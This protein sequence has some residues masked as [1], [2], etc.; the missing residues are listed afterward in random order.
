MG[1]GRVIPGGPEWP[2]SLIFSVLAVILVVARFYRFRPFLDEPHAFRQA[3][4]SYSAQ[5]FYRFGMNIFRP[6]IISMGD[7]RH[8]LIEF[9]VPE[10]ITAIVYHVTGPTLL[11][12]RLV[13][14]GF[15]LGSAY[16]LFRVIAL[17]QDRLL[18]WVA[19]LIYMAA[20][21][22]IYFSRAIHIDSAALCFGHA[23]LFYFLRYGE[24]G[25]RRDLVCAFITSA[26]GFLVK[27]PY[28]FYLILPA[29]YIQLA[30]GQ[31]RHA[32]IS[33]LAF[34]AALTVGLAWFSYAQSVNRRAPDLSFVRGY[35]ITND[36]VDFYIGGAGQRLSGE[37]WRTIGTRLRREIAADFWWPLVPLA[38][39]W[40]RRLR[41]AWSFAA[42]WT[43]GSFVFLFAFF[44]VNSLHNYYQLNF[45]APFALWM[46]IPLYGALVEEGRFARLAQSL[47]LVVLAAYV[48]AG[49]RMAIRN[50]Y[51]VDTVGIDVGEFVHARTS[52]RDLVIMAFNDA[53]YLDPRYL[54]YAQRRGWSIR[55]QWLEPRAIEGLR[56]QGA[57]AVVTSDLWPAP[58]LTRRYLEGLKLVDTLEIGNHHVFL[59]RVD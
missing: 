13:S 59:R 29:L 4:T 35:E 48:A 22:G 38:V 58:E 34:A 31:R 14:I 53:Y 20:P 33:A 42:V 44:P 57:T 45:I 51:Q 10:W 30:H 46:A 15:F 9:P 7:Y 27:A 3:W 43:L 16:F 6:S 39:V 55:A 25:R 24:T 28:V 50:Y 2:L 56:A 1:R 8:I 54:Y 17:V 32:V 19:V 40:R 52:D 26:L 12:D 37:K 36:R 41:L 11:A 5:D 23:F 49:I 18:A 21:L 47:A